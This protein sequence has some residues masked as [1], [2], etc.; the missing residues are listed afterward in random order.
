MKV[1]GL[2]GRQYRLDLAG[3]IA[4]STDT[5][6]R[7]A[8]HLAARKLLVETYPLDAVYEEVLLPGFESGSLYA[9]FLLPGPR[10]MVEVQGQQHRKYV[11]HFH[12]STAGFRRQVARDG[13]KIEFCEANNIV[14]V[15]LRDDATEGWADDI[16]RAVGRK[17]AIGIG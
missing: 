17:T 6:P 16:R 12:G 13:L 14:L 2:D 11:P 4:S 9:D 5:R 10:L 8:G 15:H 3:R 7:S 1:I